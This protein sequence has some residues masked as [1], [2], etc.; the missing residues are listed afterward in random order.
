ML[1]AQDEVGEEQADEAEGQQGKAVAE[2]VVFLFRIDAAETVSE[3]LKRAD[4]GIEPRLAARIEHLHEVE[5]ER[6]GEQQEC[7]EEKRKL[8]P[9]VGLSHGGG[10][11]VG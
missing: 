3:P 9:G 8:E 6:F 7:A 10:G 1:V 4:D 2:P 11:W 5:A